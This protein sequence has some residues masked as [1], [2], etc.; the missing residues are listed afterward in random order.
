ME[1]VARLERCDRARLK[2][3]NRA[4]GLMQVNTIHLPSLARFGVGIINASFSAT[5]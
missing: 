2:D 3:G 5:V 1:R 4:L